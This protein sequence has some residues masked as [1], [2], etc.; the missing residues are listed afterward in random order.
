MCS[1]YG[2]SVHYLDQLH[3]AVSLFPP[4]EQIIS[5]YGV[6]TTAGVT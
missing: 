2:S 3:I 6:Q 4:L 1:T 5:L